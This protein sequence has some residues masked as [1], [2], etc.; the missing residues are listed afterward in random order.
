M[1]QQDRLQR[2]QKRLQEQ[3]KKIAEQERRLNAV[4]KKR[5]AQR[6]KFKR[7][8]EPKQNQEVLITPNGFSVVDPMDLSLFRGG[9]QVPLVRVL[10]PD[11]TS[12]LAPADR[13]NYTL[14]QDVK[15][16]EPTFITE[17][18]KKKKKKKAAPRQKAPARTVRKRTRRPSSVAPRRRTAPAKQQPKPAPTPEDQSIRAKSEKQV[19]QLLLDKGAI[20]LKP[21]TLQLEPSFEYQT[22]SSSNVAING[23]SLF[24]AIIIGTIRVDDIQRQVITGSLKARYGIIN[25]LQIDA[26]VPFVRRSET[27]VLGVGTP[28]VTERNITGLGIGD[29]EI[30]LTGQPLIGRGWIPN[31]LVRVGARIPTG[32]DVFQIPTVTIGP[33][34]QTRLVRAPTGN[35]FWGIFATATAVWSIDP[36]A[37]FVGGGYTFN[38]PRNISPTVGNIDPGDS[39]SYFT[40]MNIAV[41]ERVS[42]NLS[43]VGQNTF[44]TFQNGNKVPNTSFID[45]RVTIGTSIGLTDNISLLANAGIGLTRQ[46]PDFT[47]TVSLP[48]TLSTR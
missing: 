29:V 31:V 15:P 17:P 40:G 3:Q 4:E 2:Q 18:E 41:N 11:G 9:V 14:A 26:T 45:G 38:V 39:I 32:E 46:S 16:K 20:L 22:Y 24:N 6:K 10:M 36:V 8:P 37:F 21:G 1:Q 25:R 5:S 48:I 33:G 27:E 23:V 44:S 34:G 12:F 28:D 7:A 30:G 13:F 43:F 47:F 42:L 35:G 19:D